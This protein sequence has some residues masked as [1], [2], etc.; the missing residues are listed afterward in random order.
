MLKG[1]VEGS[2]WIWGE[3][4]EYAYS[5]LDGVWSES[6]GRLIRM[7]KTENYTRGGGPE[8]VA[9]QRTRLGGILASLT[10]LVRL[11]LIALSSS[12]DPGEY[13]A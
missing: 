8:V 9:V 3:V 7:P 5:W 6:L 11:Q 13:L 1:F 12:R 10:T 2:A 4:S